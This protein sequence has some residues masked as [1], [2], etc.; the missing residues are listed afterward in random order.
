MT[1]LARLC[2][3]GETPPHTIGW[4]EA[5]HKSKGKTLIYSSRKDPKLKPEKRF[6]KASLIL[7]KDA[8]E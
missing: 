6:L 8:K 5:L 1:D 4:C 7:R 2:P 3:C